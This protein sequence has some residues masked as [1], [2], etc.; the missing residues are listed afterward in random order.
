MWQHWYKES[1]TKIDQMKQPGL[2]NSALIF[3]TT[4]NWYSLYRKFNHAAPSPAWN[5]KDLAA[6]HN[7]A[8]G[9]IL[10]TKR[11]LNLCAQSFTWYVKELTHM[12]WVICKCSCFWRYS[13]CFT[14]IRIQNFAAYEFLYERS[15]TIAWLLIRPLTRPSEIPSEHKRIGA[16]ENG[17][18][19]TAISTGRLALRSALE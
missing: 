7:R 13:L 15:C 10:N 9:I 2:V 18:K 8:K 16:N 4:H 14:K 11:N 5:C 6:R 1:E 17:N 12:F 19:H 3:N